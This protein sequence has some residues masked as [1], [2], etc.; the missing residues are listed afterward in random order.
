MS[1]LSWKEERKHFSFEKKKQKTF[2]LWDRACHGGSCRLGFHVIAYPRA[3]LG[4]QMQ[5]QL[6][7]PPQHVLRRLGPFLT[8]QVIQ[9]GT[10]KPAAEWLAQ[11]VKR[12][13]TIEQAPN[14]RAIGAA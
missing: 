4:G 12:A 1:E 9:L 2:D 3:F 14:L 8:Y 6:G 7:T 13:R 11:I 5:A 10:R